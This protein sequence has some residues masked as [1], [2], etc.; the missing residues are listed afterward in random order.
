[1]E[2][3]LGQQTVN[4]DLRVVCQHAVKAPENLVRD[5]SLTFH[6]TLMVVKNSYKSNF[7]LTSE[8]PWWIAIQ[9]WI[10]HVILT[11]FGAV[12]ESCHWT[13]CISRWS[14][15]QLCL[16]FIF[17]QLSSCKMNARSKELCMLSQT[18]T[19]SCQQFWTGISKNISVPC[20]SGW[21]RFW[22][23]NGAC[24]K[25][26]LHFP[27][28]AVMRPWLRCVHVVV[29]AVMCPWL[30]CVHVVVTVLCCCVHLSV[31][32]ETEQWR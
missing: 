12:W 17:V 3:V 25:F 7:C 14:S 21:N 5:F 27:V 19:A 15:Y 30:R 22:S 32:L 13:D 31:A 2:C 24:R 10:R 8:I 28:T 6:F 1:M 23:E 26:P 11:F 16:L 18:I 20:D 9:H 4:F 29:T